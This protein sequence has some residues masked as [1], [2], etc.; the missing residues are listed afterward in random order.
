MIKDT[1]SE[2]VADILRRQQLGLNKYG[3]TVAN[4]P[5]SPHAWLKHA[6]EE[7]LDQAI[8]MKRLLQ[9]LEDGN[10]RSQG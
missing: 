2:V 6:Y 9:E 1:E 4:N 7:C 8:Y 3:T 5:L 10:P